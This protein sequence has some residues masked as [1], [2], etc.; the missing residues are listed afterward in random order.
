[1][2]QTI[3]FTPML[4]SQVYSSHFCFSFFPYSKGHSGNTHSKIISLLYVKGGKQK[5]NALCA[6]KLRH[7]QIAQ[8]FFILA[9]LYADKLKEEF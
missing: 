1:M 7:S 4:L 2:T 8:G 9:Q 5:K 3:L 6:M